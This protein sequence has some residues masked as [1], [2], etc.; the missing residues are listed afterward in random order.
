MRRECVRLQR[1]CARVGRHVEG[2]VPRLGLGH[3][4]KALASL[5]IFYL[6]HFDVIIDRE[7][8]NIPKFFERCIT[9]NISG[10]RIS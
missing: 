1:S 4:E 5:G 9:L 6:L 3:V 10:R 7:P 8:P 2:S